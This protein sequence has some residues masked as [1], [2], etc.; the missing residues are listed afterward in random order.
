[1]KPFRHLEGTMA[2]LPIDNVDTDQI[3]PAAFLTTTSRRGLGPGL[4]AG[5]RRTAS[6]RS[7][8]GFV[9][10]DPRYSSAEI[11]VVGD[12]FGCGSSREHA[13][14]ALLDHGIRA[15]FSTRFADIFRQNAL[16]NGLLAIE[17]P[18]DAHAALMTLARSD[19]EARL[20]IDL[21]GQHIHTPHGKL[22]PFE[23]D[24]FHRRCLLEGVDALG[25]LL[26]RQSSIEAYERARS[27]GFD[28]RTG[29]GREGSTR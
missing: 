22:V 4:F 9:L 24:P 16:G 29:S 3:I 15:I 8:P 10:D 6:G 26:T 19:P 14:W 28:T 17:L 1:M 25:F 23:L 21:V 11:L 5:W 27:D 12:N 7:R 2:P 13:P 18:K 20:G